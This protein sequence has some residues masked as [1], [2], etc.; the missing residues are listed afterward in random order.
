MPPTFDAKVVGLK[1]CSLNDI[2]HILKEL[3]YTLSNIPHSEGYYFIYHLQTCLLVGFILPMLNARILI[4]DFE[5]MWKIHDM[6][7]W[8][9]LAYNIIYG[10]IVFN[11]AHG[12]G[13]LEHFTS[14]LGAYAL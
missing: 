14:C 7:F 8:E 1:L 12:Y 9:Y 5:P 2:P 4:E 6:E 10:Y 11:D 3:E 13:V